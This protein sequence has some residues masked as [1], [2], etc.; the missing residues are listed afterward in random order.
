MP[1][2]LRGAAFGT[3]LLAEL[4]RIAPA[5]AGVD[6]GHHH[7]HGPTIET[8]VNSHAYF[9]S[10]GQ[11]NGQIADAQRKIA[12]KNRDRAA[13]TFGWLSELLDGGEDEAALADLEKQRRA[14][15][16]QVP[17]LD[18]K[19][20]ETLR[21]RGLRA[22]IPLDG[23]HGI[24]G[25]LAFVDALEAKTGVPLASMST[26]AQA[27]LLKS[28]L[29]TTDPQVLSQQLS[30]LSWIPNELLH[31]FEGWRFDR[32]PTAETFRAADLV[33]DAGATVLESD[34]LRGL[35]FLDDD[36]VT[37]LAGAVRTLTDAGWRFTGADHPADQ[38]RGGYRRTELGALL[39]F[40]SAGTDVPLELTD[41]L[42]A[43]SISVVT[44]L[45]DFSTAV[46]DLAA[47]GVVPTAS[48]FEYLALMTQPESS[49]AAAAFT[50]TLGEVV[51]L[52]QRPGALRALIALA[53]EGDVE[54][55][56]QVLGQCSE[57]LGRRL[58]TSEAKAYLARSDKGESIDEILP[59]DGV[60]LAL[61][62]D[63]RATAADVYL[64]SNLTDGERSRDTQ[65]LI[66]TLA[67]RI[68]PGP[69]RQDKSASY[70]ESLSGNAAKLTRSDLARMHVVLD[71]LEDPSART[72]IAN[73]IAADVARNDTELGG[74][75]KVVDGRRTFVPI[76]PKQTQSNN[77]Y[78]HPNAEHDP[79][80][81]F[82]TAHFHADGEVFAGP[83]SSHEGFFADRGWSWSQAR[84]DLVITRIDDR[85]FGVDYYNPAGAVVDLGVF[86]AD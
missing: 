12:D 23:R 2:L 49:S 36:A 69:E 83:S 38:R 42:S 5:I 26:R 25:V 72:A 33:I 74:A 40:S 65:T 35:S 59:P 45:D 4:V 85:T 3:V 67:Q 68:Q 19:A 39:P 1:T 51:E 10:L 32:M 27:N 17:E 43:R 47:T 55:M 41:A 46:R 8:V 79:M 60:A 7:R 57:R 24:M 52:E 44:T 14:L 73:H 29:R 21:R 11:L 86:R 61:E 76:T 37:R 75:F 54:E 50:R 31:D 80:E 78:V 63:P 13:A 71:I 9:A 6:H 82:V 56:S 18:Q 64:W 34:D 84:S 20:Y 16:Q 53:F 66:Q 62:H 48:H 30:M 77:V 28:R 22:H 81:L 70:V 58:S 15:K